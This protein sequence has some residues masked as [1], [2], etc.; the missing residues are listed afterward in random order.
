MS[1]RRADDERFALQ[2]GLIA[3]GHAIR[4]ELREARIARD[5]AAVRARRL[6]DELAELESQIRTLTEME[7][8]T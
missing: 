3:R 1:S 6:E 8:K 5:D 2:Q 7:E 4:F